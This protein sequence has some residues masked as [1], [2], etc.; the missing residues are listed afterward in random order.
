M[1]DA[2]RKRLVWPRR[3]VGRLG[4]TG[5]SLPLLPFPPL[6]AAS[7][8]GLWHGYLSASAAGALRA[9]PPYG[10]SALLPVAWAAYLVVGA[11]RSPWGQLT[12]KQET[13][14]LK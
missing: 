14:M 4:R 5:Q 1:E 6:V 2:I 11:Y 13:A 7:L 3:L 9:W 12:N 10:G 8:V